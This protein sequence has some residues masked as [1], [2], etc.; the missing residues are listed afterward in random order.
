M[1]VYIPKSD[2][3]D[4]LAEV[5]A[6]DQKSLQELAVFAGVD[7]ETFADGEAYNNA[8]WDLVSQDGYNPF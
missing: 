2:G 4:F 7:V 5:E 8:L 6:S 1:N 3:G